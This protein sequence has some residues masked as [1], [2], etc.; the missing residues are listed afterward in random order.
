MVERMSDLILHTKSRIAG[1]NADVHIYSN[2][3]E[4]SKMPHGTGV[5]ITAI[6]LAF[7]TAFISLIWLR[8]SFKVQETETIPASKISSV[9]TKKDGPVNTIVTVVTSGATI[10]FRTSHDKAQMISRTLSSLITA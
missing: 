10:E 3:I 9:Q 7:C 6:V 1:K 8:P 4:W 2:R 5:N